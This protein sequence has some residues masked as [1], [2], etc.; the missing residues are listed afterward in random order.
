MLSVYIQKNGKNEIATYKQYSPTFC[1]LG[2]FSTR[3]AIGC[4]WG[5]N[6]LIKVGDS[7][8]RTTIAHNL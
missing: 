1:Q 2:L 8:A 3:A 7:I 4:N 6:G 5:K